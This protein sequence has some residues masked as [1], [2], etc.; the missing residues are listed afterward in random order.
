[1]NAELGIRNAEWAE[2]TDEGE[3]RSGSGNHETHLEHEKQG[4]SS[5]Q[6]DHG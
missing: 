6:K 1:M 3:S 4:N 5:G 2:E